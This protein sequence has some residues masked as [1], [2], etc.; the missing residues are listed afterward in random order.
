MFKGKAFSSGW[1]AQLQNG[2]LFGRR[3]SRLI[4]F[5]C[6]DS[7]L[8][9]ARYTCERK[10]AKGRECLPRKRLAQC[11]KHAEKKVLLAEYRIPLLRPQKPCNKETQFPTVRGRIN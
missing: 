3:P 2:F 9:W 8:Q 1:R 4:E 11:E 5:A 7:K 10:Q 6:F